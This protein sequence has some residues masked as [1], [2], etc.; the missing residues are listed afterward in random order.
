MRQLSFKRHRFPADII[1]HSVWL[2][3]LGLADDY[4]VE[5]GFVHAR[6]LWR[7][8]PWGGEEGDS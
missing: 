8:W 1:R 7:G 6:Y 5:D 2:H 4:R 3:A